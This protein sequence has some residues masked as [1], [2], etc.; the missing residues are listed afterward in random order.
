LA[1][2]G[3]LHWQWNQGTHGQNTILNLLENIP[4]LFRRPTVFIGRRSYVLVL[5]HMRSYSSVLCHILGSHPEVSGYAE[6][7]QSYHGAVDLVRVRARVFRSLDDELD[8][9]LV[10]DK[11]LHNDYAVSLDVVDR[12]NVFPIFLVRRP[13]ETIASILEMGRSIDV[14]WYSDVGA[15]TSYYEERLAELGRIAGAAR[16]RALAIKA[17]SVLDRT[18]RV[19][20]AISAYL[21]LDCPL[22]ER[23]RIFR[24]TGEV[25]WGDSSGAI[26]AGR[27]LR[28]RPVERAIE[29][30]EPDL[31]RATQAY[32]EC[33]EALEA[34]CDAV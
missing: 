23:Y 24:H 17:E 19:L 8:G 22:A 26:R 25:G 28:P 7:H 13:V 4:L 27:I 2:V 10:L 12:S 5:S 14:G 3:R 11:V 6:M 30:G 15:A 33:L 29:L 31:A 32:T 9:R 20:A 18:D 21:G 34:S 1:S 16:R